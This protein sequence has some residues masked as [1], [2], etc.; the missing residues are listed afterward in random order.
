MIVFRIV[1]QI[2]S[3]QN[4]AYFGIISYGHMSPFHIV[5]INNALYKRDEPLEMNASGIYYVNMP[6]NLIGFS[7]IVSDINTDPNL[8]SEQDI[9]SDNNQ[10]SVINQIINNPLY[11]PLSRMPYLESKSPDVQFSIQDGNSVNY[12][13]NYPKLFAP[14]VSTYSVSGYNVVLFGKAYSLYKPNNQILHSN[15][16]GL[17]LLPYDTVRFD[18]ITVRIDNSLNGFSVISKLK[19]LINN[20]ISNPHVFFYVIGSNMIASQPTSIGIF[21]SESKIGSSELEHKKPVS[22]G[23]L[24]SLSLDHS[25]QSSHSSNININDFFKFV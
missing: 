25:L 11:L 15:Y 6:D 10:V 1:R 5:N 22:H 13:I 16:Y 18:L 17:Y 24:T 14:D 7:P 3:S 19:T 9:L 20:N 21:D 8:D 23:Y 2:S 12:I 4:D